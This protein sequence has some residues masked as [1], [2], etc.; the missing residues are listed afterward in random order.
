MRAARLATEGPVGELPPR[1]SALVSFLPAEASAGGRFCC[2]LDSMG[3]L[4]KGLVPCRI[5]GAEY[6]RHTFMVTA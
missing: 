2:G 4:V 3:H 6:V 1:P 5:D